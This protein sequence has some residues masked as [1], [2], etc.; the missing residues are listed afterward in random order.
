MTFIEGLIVWAVIWIFFG[1]AVHCFIRGSFFVFAE[2]SGRGD[3]ERQRIGQKAVQRM[4]LKYIAA[5]VALSAT[6]YAIMK[7]AGF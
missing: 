5:S 4:G 1:Y 7:V 2:P 3:I 6:G